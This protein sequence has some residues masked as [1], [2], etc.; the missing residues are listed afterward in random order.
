MEVITSDKLTLVRVQWTVF[1]QINNLRMIHIER[2]LI[3]MSL[4]TL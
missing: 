2:S 3:T 1:T 4:L